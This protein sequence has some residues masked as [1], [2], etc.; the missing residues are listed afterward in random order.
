MNC[1]DTPAPLKMALSIWWENSFNGECSFL[2]WHKAGDL[3][4]GNDFACILHKCMHAC[5]HVVLY[6][7]MC[8][9]H[10]FTS[11]LLQEFSSY[12]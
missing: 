4:R 2:P 3:A 8:D 12:S 6:I 10:D 9:T 11:L 7:V 5:M 1:K